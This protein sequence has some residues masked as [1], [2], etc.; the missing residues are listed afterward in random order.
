MITWPLKPVGDKEGREGADITGTKLAGIE[1]Y[2]INEG[3]IGGPAE[4]VVVRN[5]D[6][7]G[8]YAICIGS[9]MSGGVNNIYE[10][11]LKTSSI[12]SSHCWH[13]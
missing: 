11:S 12:Y 10:F 4:Y 6:F 7:R 5:C 1:S 13:I 9:E 8:H 3:K 2:Y